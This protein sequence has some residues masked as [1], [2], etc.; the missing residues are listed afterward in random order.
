MSHAMFI[1]VLTTTMLAAGFGLGLAYF[2]TLRRTVVIFASGRGW[3]GLLGLTLGRIAA[4]VLFLA[5]AAKLGAAT[6]IAAL[7]G[8]LL[9]RTIAVRAANRSR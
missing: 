2:A 3:L 9:A 5:V 4:A 6:L 1:P 8:L 7:G